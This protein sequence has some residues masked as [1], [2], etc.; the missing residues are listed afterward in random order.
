MAKKR[1]RR[2]PNTGY[3]TQAPNKTWS[4]FFPR[5]GGGYHVRKGFHTRP[6][7]EAWLDSLVD[8]QSKKEDIGKGQQQVDAWVDAWADRAARERGWKA[9]TVV[10]VEWK[11]GYIKPYIG[12]M[13]LADVMP[14]HIDTMVDDLSTS[15]AE[16]TIRQIRNYTFQVFESAVKRRYIT[17][18]PVIKPERRKRA[19]Q[20]EPERLSIPSAVRLLHAAA[21]SFHEL[22]WWL[23]LTLG[24]RAG[25]VCG[26][27]WGDV[28]LERGIIHVDQEVT[29]LR[30]KTHKDLPKGDK[31]RTLPI[32]R[33]LIPLFRDHKAWY[34]RRATQGTQRGTWQENTLVFPGRSGRPMNPTSLWHA[35]RRLTDACHMPPIKTHNLRHTA[36]AFYTNAGAPQHITSVILG[37]STNITGHYAPPDAEAMRAWVERVYGV[38]VGET[39]QARKTG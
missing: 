3:T 2:K 16:S 30:G 12:H 35:L 6:A 38:L 22:A 24:L 7:A 14:D 4:A 5:F 13:A 20:K 36:G 17:F 8:R 28:D 32:A 33:A 18:N 11:L 9:K 23:L 34:L 15:L 29:D 39:G 10:D 21:G 37:H 26:L 27:R 19:K 1:T 25:E 31:Q